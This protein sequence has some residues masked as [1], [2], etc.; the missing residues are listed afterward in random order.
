MARRTKGGFG[1]IVV[2]LAGIGLIGHFVG[3]KEPS[4]TERPEI[5]SK[6]SPADDVGAL[7][8]QHDSAPSAQPLKAPERKA[9]LTRWVS[10]NRVA[11]RAGPGTEFRTID[12]YGRGRRLTLLSAFGSWTKVR[13]ELTSQEGWIASDYLTD[14]APAKP[15]PERRAKRTADEPTA[16]TVPRISNSAI[17]QKI[18]AES[19]TEY[20]SNTGN[21]PCPY[22]RDRRG[23]RCGGRSAHT[24]PGGESPICY[25]S[26][27]TPEMIEAFRSR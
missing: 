13:D 20:L 14:K 1:S 2:L 24:R 5:A 16:V 23:R 15:S 12:R 7:N 8:S 21:C 27:V 26:D 17:V 3:G 18:I 6:V 4:R 19:I 11:F 9:N 25:A 10:G 22:N